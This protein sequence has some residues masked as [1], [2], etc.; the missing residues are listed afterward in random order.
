MNDTSC[1]T[2]FI[3]F[4]CDRPM[5]AVPFQS[6]AMRKHYFNNPETGFFKKVKRKVTPKNPMTG[7]RQFNIRKWNKITCYASSY[8]LPSDPSM[9]T[10]MMKG[11]LTNVLPMILIGGWINWAF[12]GFLTSKGF[13]YLLKTKE[14]TQRPLY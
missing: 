4:M 9:L 3:H 1:Q 11:N 7:K 6:F 14:Y 10:D 13:C 8:H 5:I 12:S 2:I